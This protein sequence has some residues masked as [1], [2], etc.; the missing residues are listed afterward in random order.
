MKSLLIFVSLFFSASVSFSQ[1]YKDPKA[2]VEDRV[3]DVLSRLTPE[4]KIDYI[5]GTNS[6]YI[7]A[8]ARLG[9][10]EIRMSDA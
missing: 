7:R 4:E 2:P 1:V 10:P 6:M 8:I 5:G 3:G 9:I